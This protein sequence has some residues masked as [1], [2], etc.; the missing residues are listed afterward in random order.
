MSTPDEFEVGAIERR[1]RK[2]ATRRVYARVG[3]MWHAS[4]FLMANIAM[5]AINQR[6][7]PT[8]AWFVWPL[9]AWGTALALHALA[10]FSSGG[11]TE[12]L[13]QAQIQREKQR[14]GLA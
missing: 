3:L 14:R 13:I 4:V 9:A 11:M 1:I 12:D 6:Y 8:V 5:Y 7:T 2:K 10:T